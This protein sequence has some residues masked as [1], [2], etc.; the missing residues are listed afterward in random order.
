MRPGAG[1]RR[2]TDRAVIVLPQPDSPTT[3][4]V[5]PSSTWRLTPST[6]RTTPRD[7]KN[8]VFMSSMRRIVAN[9]ALHP[10]IE[11]VPEAVAD[12]RERE[13]RDGDRDGGERD[14]VG[15]AEDGLVAVLDHHA[16]ARRGRRDAD[17]QIAEHRLQE[18]GLGDA[19]RQRD[20]DR[21]QRVGHEVPED[22]LQVRRADRSRRL[23]VLLLL[24]REHLAA[25]EPGQ[26]DP[27]D[28]ADRHEDRED[29]G[30]EH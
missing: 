10:R 24:D 19:E 12:E 17:A 14:L 11:R 30:A 3:P 5:S 22:D 18:D 25:D 16:P 7:V 6:A 9:S 28:D 26:A 20:D 13:H 21:T 8:W 23:D 15:R 27:V 1:T 2:S 4:T 29:A